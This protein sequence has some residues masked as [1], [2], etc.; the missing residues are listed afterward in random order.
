MT[1]DNRIV[2]AEGSVNLADSSGNNITVTAID[3]GAVSKS[4]DFAEAVTSKA[5]DLATASVASVQA[6]SKDALTA[7]KEAYGAAYD[8]A[9]QSLAQA[10][11]DSKAGEQKMLTF[12]LVAVVALVAAKAVR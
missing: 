6:S 3:A 10:W 2:S 11:A 7:V 4:F 5:A 12:G 9:K 1:K 8:G